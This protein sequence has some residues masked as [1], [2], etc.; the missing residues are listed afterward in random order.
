M[1]LH[2]FQER[3]QVEPIRL[4]Q[5]VK[6]RFDSTDR[7]LASTVANEIATAYIQADLDARFSITERANDWLNS[8]L[9]YLK[10]KLDTAEAELQSY[11]EKEGL[12]DTKS[13]VLGATG[14][15]VDE[16]NQKLVE[17]RVRRTLAEQS[18]NQVRPGA[19]NLSQVPAIISHPSVQRA[20]GAEIEAAR[21]FTDA[22]TRFGPAHPIYGAAE[23]ELRAARETAAREVESVAA[24]IRK[25][26]QAARAAEISL[27]QTLS[28]AR[29]SVQGINRKEIRQSSL[30]REVEV[31][32]QLYNLFLSRQRETSAA[33]SFQVSPARVIDPAVPAL[34]PF[35]SQEATDHLLGDAHDADSGAVGAALWR[36]L[37]D[38]IKRADD[39]EDQIG[40][41]LIAAVP[42]LSG[43]Q[44][45]NA[46][47]MLL[48]S[49]ISH[50]SESIR[51]IASAVQLLCSTHRA[52]SS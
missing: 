12:V 21:R 36:R 1:V 23:Q 8:R 50:Y 18:F 17:A 24:S 14:R 10:T 6:I 7:Q 9:A 26:Y 35:K 43:S 49:P 3:L 2:R 44:A 41:P 51:S 52:K 20:R 30:E 48:H 46:Y 5:L 40:S 31:N 34:Q 32:K 15:Q 38:T 33:S 27:E 29:V 47:T 13:Q 45:Q 42:K 22:G 19:D 4:S 25:E 11:R 28:T 37:D 39:L 16:L